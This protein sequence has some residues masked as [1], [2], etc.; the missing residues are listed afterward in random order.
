VDVTTDQDKVMMLAFLHLGARKGEVF[1]LTWDDIRF[2]TMSIRVWTQK[3]KNSDWESDWLPMTS[4]L[5]RAL[6]WWWENRPFKDKEHVFVQTYG[7][8]SPWNKPGEPF[9]DR[10]HFIRK[11]CAEAKV[12]Y[13]SY[14]SMRHL[15]A[16]ILYKN[17]ERLSVI[18]QVLRHKHPSTTE[19]YLQRLGLEVVRESMEKHLTPKGKVIRYDFN[20]D[21]E[22]EEAFEMASEG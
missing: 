7:S 9:T 22:K 19:R 14:H 15:T 10:M 12:K 3:R 21:P 5:K 2:D 17:G 11:V 16:T 1:R 8:D 6:L 4:E 13:F 20:Q 18:Q